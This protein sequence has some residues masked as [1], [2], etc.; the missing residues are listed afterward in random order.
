MMFDG[1]RAQGHVNDQLGGVGGGGGVKET[2]GADE[3]FC[4]YNYAI[5][6]SIDHD[7]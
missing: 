6:L 5:S 2:I 7:S 1:G 4:D 3:S